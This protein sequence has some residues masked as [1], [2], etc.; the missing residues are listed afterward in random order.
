MAASSSSGTSGMERCTRAICA[1]A[2]GLPPA[3]AQ[4][5]APTQKTAAQP[6]HPLVLM[7]RILGDAPPRRNSFRAAGA[8]AVDVR[9]RPC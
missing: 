3:V 8:S 9:P 6:A 4:V 1:S 7:R 2:A 5:H